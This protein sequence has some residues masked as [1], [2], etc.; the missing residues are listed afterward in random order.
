M[1]FREEMEK[2]KVIQTEIDGTK[3]E[4][5][6]EMEKNENLEQFKQRLTQDLNHYNSRCKGHNYTRTI[7]IYQLT[8]AIYPFKM[9]R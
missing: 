4:A 5:S 1:S 9:T 8:L 7:N 6:N 3:K 2:T